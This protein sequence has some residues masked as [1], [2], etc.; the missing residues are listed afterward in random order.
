VR[1]V[2]KDLNQTW[3]LEA[4]FPG[5]SASPQFAAYLDSLES[6]TEALA[7]EVAG[8]KI[9][10]ALAWA[11]RLTKI[12]ELSKRLR[13]AGG[14]VSCL[15]AQNVN[16]RQARIVGGRLGQVRA[17]F[18]SVMTVNDREMLAI[19]DGEWRELLETG[20]M[21]PLAFNLN[22]RRERA[23]EML[24]TEQETL[25][26]ALSVDGY[27]GWSELYDLVTGRM[28][29][30]V[31]E[32]GKTVTLSMGQ[33]SN[34]MSDPDPAF[35]ASLMEKWEQAWA[36]EANLCALALNRLAGYRLALYKKRGWD[37]FLKEPLEINRMSKA[38]LDAMWDTIDRN[39]DRLVTY[40]RRKKQYLGLGKFG[41][42]DYGAPVGKAESKMRYDEAA[43]FIVEQFGQV[44]PRMSA[45]ATSAF[46]ERWI[47]SQD[48]P[49]KR[50]GGFCTSFPESQQ[51]RVF[52]T[53]SGSLGNVSTVAHEL[54]H[55]FHQS[56]M[57]DLP[58]MAQQY[59]MIVAETASTFS[60]LVVADA[61][62]GHARSREEKI[63]LIDD[64][65]Q[66]A[67]ALLMNIEARFL[68]ETRFYEARRKGVVSVERLNEL[69]LEAQKEAFADGLD[70]YHPH[71]W[72]SKLHFYST[73]VPFYN[74]PYTFGY[75][76]SAGIYARAKEERSAFEQ[77]YADLLR[78]T[79][80]MRVEDLAKRH[81]NADLTKPGFWQSAI[82]SVLSDLPEYLEM[83]KQSR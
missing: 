17:G 40:M 74:F 3:D 51:S 31:E 38:T 77:K 43:D 25:V 62:V 37:S 7:A 52:V 60:E 11:D 14:F 81:I 67:V 27:H 44:S 28:S 69:M 68:F 70:V 16:D 30:T 57:N 5:G 54:G 1:Y 71:F 59:A 18:A 76:F 26:N 72:A 19:P 12:Q 13:Q 15:D 33:M 78:D 21:A 65:L 50:M 42:Q 23:K 48:R 4:F 32:K 39:K 35:R 80:R 41:W 10:G 56:L 53:F 79:G 73:G 58:P 83:T 24:P 20:A 66:R 9:Q 36:K 34:R 22:E 45:L 49:G 47:E 8:G 55:A 29:V 46:R 75:L 2:F 64:K 61:A 63:M 6:D 82:D